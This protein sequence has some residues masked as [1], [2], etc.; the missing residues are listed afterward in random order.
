MAKTS[1]SVW[2]FNTEAS[3]TYVH[4]A[5]PYLTFVKITRHAELIAAWSFFGRLSTPWNT[6]QSMH[7]AQNVFCMPDEARDGRN[8][9]LIDKC[10]MF[11]VHHAHP[12]LTLFFSANTEVWLWQW[13]RCTCQYTHTCD[14]PVTCHFC[15]ALHCVCFHAYSFVQRTHCAS[16]CLSHLQWHCRRWQHTR[17]CFP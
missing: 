4:Y 13:W 7:N 5:H 3:S 17:N 11:C 9:A 12:Y 16:E 6:C 1:T 15:W 8:V 14:L 10:F 2:V